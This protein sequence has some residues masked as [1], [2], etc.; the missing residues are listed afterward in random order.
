MRTSPSARLYLAACLAALSLPFICTATVYDTASAFSATANPAGLWSYGYSTELGSPMVLDPERASDNGLDIWRTNIWLGAPAVWHNGTNRTLTN[1]T[2]TLVVPPG[3]LGLHPGPGGQFSLLRFS[4][5]ADGLY[6]L[7]GAFSGLDIVGTTTDVHVLTNGF[8]MFDGLVNGYGPGSSVSF[9]RAVNLKAGDSVDFA[10][11]WGANHEFS[12]DSTGLSAQITSGST[13]PNCQPPPSGLVSWWRAEGNASDAGD[14]NNGSLAGNATY[15]PGRVGQAFV[16]DGNGDGVNVG[17]GTNLWLQNFSVEAWVKRASSS[18]VSFN[19]N[20]NG[21]IF[22]SGGFG[23]AGF[24]LDSTGRPWLCYLGQWGVTAGGP[25]TDTNWHHLA[26]TKS[27]STVVFYIDGVAYPAPAYNPG[28]VLVPPAV[29]GAWIH[30]GTVV[31]NTLYGSIDEVGVYNRALSAAEIQA[32]YGADGAGKCSDL[33]APSVTTQPLSQLATTGSGVTLNV[34]A[35]GSQPL[36]YQWRFNGANL[37]GKTATSLALANV[38]LTN[39][40]SYSVVVTN[41]AGSRTSSNAV[42]TV[43]PA[44]LCVAAPSGLVSWWAANSNATD[45]IGPNQG[46]LA[47]NATYGPGRVGQAFVFDGRGDVV[48]LGTTSN[49][50]LQT[51]TIETWVKRSSTSVVSYDGN[52][53]GHFFTAG[54][55]SA[56][57]FYMDPSGQP[58]LGKMWFAGVGPGVRVTD[59]NWHHLAVTKNQSAVVFYID[60]VAYPGPAYDPGFFGSSPSG[61]GGWYYSGVVQNSFYGSIDELAVYNR[62]L[63]AAEIQTIYSADG[64]GK[65]FTPVA[66]TITS[67]PA[68]TVALVGS[69][70]HFNVRASG[71]QPLS[72]QWRCNDAAL[73]GKTA[74]SLALANVQL[75]NAGTYSVVVCNPAG[76]MTSSNA[77]LGVNPLACMPPPQGLVSWWRAESNTLDSVDGNL[78]TL[79]G[80][81]SYGPAPS[82]QA[83][84]FDGAHGGV[85]LGNPTNLQLQVFT[86]ES[87]VKRASTSRVSLDTGGNAAGTFYSYGPGGYGFQIGADGR[88]ALGKISY[89]AVLSTAG[90]ITDT[91]WHHVAV[92]KNGSAV[93]FYLDG[94]VNS[95]V[96]YEPGFVLSTPVTIGAWGPGLGN[97]FLGSVDE[98]AVYNRALATNEV[99]GLYLSGVAGKC[100]VPPFIIRQPSDQR[101][102]SWFTASFSVAA[103]GSPLLHYQWLFNGSN[104]AGATHPLLR[105]TNIQE[106]NAGTYAVRVSNTFGSVLS[107]EA[108]LSLARL[109]IAY[110]D[111]S[112]LQS[113][114]QQPGKVLLEFAGA[115]GT[116]YS[117]QASTNLVDWETI[118]EASEV[119]DSSFQFSD[120]QAGDFPARFYRLVAP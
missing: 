54:G 3:G 115:S 119:D 24:L 52:G 94:A 113:L 107:R 37:A 36:S 35:S 72:Y 42:L 21:H 114:V 30:H 110:L 61:V 40:G 63:T 109:S 60:G 16:F 62:A 78:G 48:N 41:L 23:G 43:N 47:G 101:L 82:G 74:D 90:G 80:T 9:A 17:S 104:I 100:A 96:T 22:S 51:F 5:P 88:L 56:M 65:C 32:V 89:G 33:I 93:S 103:G 14:G 120:S 99:Q 2:G 87:W 108:Q 39:A 111:P 55:P 15:G 105:L 57:G 84:R 83:F 118:G 13:P 6:Q 34:V 86:L 26:V 77:L 29:I 27:G 97:C 66:P 28:F 67:Q 73:V 11:G 79:A 10:V 31:D 70:V 71:T 76:C 95:R 75:T 81:A 38:Q 45:N 106:M 64:A 85:N 92:S 46:T 53:N 91:N 8:P 1:S 116:P 117:V 98:L 49:L 112:K 59:T 102:I 69:S 68:S 18:I 4:V 12:Y 25:V 58:V 50:W 19:G 44:P 20:G 7:S